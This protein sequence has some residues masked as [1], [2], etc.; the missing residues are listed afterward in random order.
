MSGSGF[1]LPDWLKYLGITNMP[2]PTL[3]PPSDS[4]K[5]ADGTSLA[6]GTPFTVQGQGPTS[7]DNPNDALGIWQNGSPWQDRVGLFGA[8]LRDAGQAFSTGT[9]GNAIEQYAAK[10]PRQ[11]AVNDLQAAFASG[12]ENKIRAAMMA[13]A[14]AGV[15]PSAFASANDYGRPELKMDG[16]NAFLW[17]KY[18]GKATPVANIDNGKAPPHRQIVRGSTI[19]EQDWNPT[20]KMWVD[21]PG[22]GG[23]RWE[24]GANATDNG[25]PQPP[26]AYGA[27]QFK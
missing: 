17:D 24:K 8:A 2:D 13:A 23:P 16:G 22:A 21:T 27:G 5:L 15:D 20:L 6:P 18:S 14:A 3:A 4:L 10:A 12:D 25:L 9:P 7:Q 26:A 11:K 1:V 19:V